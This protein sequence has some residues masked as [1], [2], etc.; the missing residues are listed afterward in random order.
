M[1]HKSLLERFAQEAIDAGITDKSEASKFIR[2]AL[3]KEMGVLPSSMMGMDRSLDIRGN[4]VKAGRNLLAYTEDAPTDMYANQKKAGRLSVFEGRLADLCIKMWSDAGDIVLDPFSGRVTRLAFSVENGRKY[5]GFDTSPEACKY[6]NDWLAGTEYG[7]DALIVNESLITFDGLNGESADMVFT[8]PP[9]WNSEFYGDNGNGI[10]GTESYGDFI[11][12]IAAIFCKAYAAL[13]PD[14]YFVVVVKDFYLHRQ[15]V[16]LHS[17]I[18][19]VMS[20]IGAVTWDVIAKMAS[21]TRI[22]FH[23]DIAANRRTAQTHEYVLVFR[24][25][26]HK[27]NRDQYRNNCYNKN[28]KRKEEDEGLARARAKILSDAG[29]DVSSILPILKY[30]KVK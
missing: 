12:E 19:R 27:K 5:I 4:G 22:M 18:I 23:R 3:I 10:E 24:K 30:D 8:C 17:D 11:E 25:S 1:D 9:Y 14:C 29:V 28:T 13:K 26:A 2:V 7:D 16:S 20:A 6:N 21:N 15:M